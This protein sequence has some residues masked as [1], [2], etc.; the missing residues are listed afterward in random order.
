MIISDNV[1][2]CL[3]SKDILSTVWM[4]ETR[5][6]SHIDQEKEK[7]E[8]LDHNVNVSAPHVLSKSL[9]SIKSCMAAD[10]VIQLKDIHNSSQGWWIF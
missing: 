10:T 3:Q 9:S 7:S 6:C 2:F 1:K 8:K 4:K 5:T